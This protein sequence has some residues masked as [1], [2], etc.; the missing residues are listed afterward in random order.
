MSAKH[1]KYHHV[2]NQS[3]TINAIISCSATPIFF[4]VVFPRTPKTGY[5]QMQTKEIREG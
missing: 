5:A 2:E 4:I 1:V 3:I